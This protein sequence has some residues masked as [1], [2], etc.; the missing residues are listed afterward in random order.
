MKKGAE[1]ILLLGDT[2]AGKSSSFR[3]LPPKETVFIK[4]NSNSLPFPGYESDYKLGVN[5]FVVNDLKTVG[6]L[7]RSK[8]L[9]NFKYVIVEDLNLFFNERITSPLFL[10]QGVGANTYQRWNVF[11]AD[12]IQG[13]VAPALTMSDGTYLV[14]SAH[15]E[16]KEDNII[17]MRTSGKLLDNTLRI[18]A[19]CT[20]IIHALSTMGKEGMS[21]KFLTNGDGKHLAKSPAGCLELNMPNN[22]MPLLAKIEEYR[23]GKVKDIVWK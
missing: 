16:L 4:P 8:E 12:V 14:L 10:S 5:L 17:G 11:A 23:A 2:G 21:Y 7:L 18:Q 9:S 13:F 3:D 19:Y 1:L 15:T 6:T 20:Y 22:I